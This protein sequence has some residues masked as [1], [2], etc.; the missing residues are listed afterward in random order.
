MTLRDEIA[1]G[2]Y[3]CAFDQYSDNEAVRSRRIA[4][5]GWSWEK[6]SEEMREY[7]RRQADVALEIVRRRRSEL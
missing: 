6:T 3:E 5:P 2:I 7:C 4:S 1:C